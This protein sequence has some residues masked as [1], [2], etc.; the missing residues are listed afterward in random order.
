MLILQEMKLYIIKNLTHSVILCYIH[1]Y[2]LLDGLRI[3]RVTTYIV[4]SNQV[5]WNA[6]L[7]NSTGE[8]IVDTA[9]LKSEQFKPPLNKSVPTIINPS[10]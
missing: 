8:C 10:Y 4:Q 3:W 5:H 9:Q 2:H 6:E 7:R 1:C